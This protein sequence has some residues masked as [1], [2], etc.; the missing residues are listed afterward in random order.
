MYVHIVLALWE[1]SKQKQKFK[2]RVTMR[3]SEYNV[4]K[5]IWTAWASKAKAYV[6]ACDGRSFAEVLKKG[7]S[8]NFK[9]K[10]LVSAV[11]PQPSLPKVPSPKRLLSILYKHSTSFNTCQPHVPTVA[12][13]TQN[14][15]LGL[16][17]S[18]R[19]QILASNDIVD[20]NSQGPDGGLCD[21]SSVNEEL[22]A[23]DLNTG[24]HSISMFSIPNR[25]VVHT[26]P[27]PRYKD[28]DT[29]GVGSNLLVTHSDDHLHPLQGSIRES[30]LVEPLMA[31]KGQSWGFTSRSTARVI[32]G[33]VLRIATCG[34]RTHR[35]DSL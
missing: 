19:F 35:G 7:I 24:K 21:G 10:Q 31:D 30:H 11:K 3:D 12:A 33:Q 15:G 2:K 17:L 9:V 25:P 20:S 27:P 23:N 13:T 22:V 26:S 18:N 5:N 6:N 16:N 28:L 32:L 4:P 29:Q 8:K 34:T 1:F 14:S